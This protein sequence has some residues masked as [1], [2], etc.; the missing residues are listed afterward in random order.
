MP[1]A[2]PTS[3]RFHKPNALC[4][5]NSGQIQRWPSVGVFDGSE[6]HLDII[7]VRFTGPVRVQASECKH[8]SDAGLHWLYN[9]MPSE[10]QI[11]SLK[12]EAVDAQAKSN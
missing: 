4:I 6:V 2:R 9:P 5:R 1:I 11:V 3:R 8:D 12:T 10:N 7:E